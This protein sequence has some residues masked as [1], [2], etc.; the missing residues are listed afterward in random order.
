[1][2]GSHSLKAWGY[3]LGVLKGNYG[4]RQDAW[5]RWTPEMQ[6][7]CENDTLVTKVL[8]QRCQQAIGDQNAQFASDIEHELAWY[9]AQQERNGAPFNMEAAVALQ[10]KL[11]AKREVIGKELR[12]QFGSWL[13][14]NGKPVTPKRDNKKKG[15]FVGAPYTKL[16][17]VEFNP[18]S[19]DHFSKILQERFGWEPQD[20]TDGGKPKMDD[21]ALESL[22]HIPAAAKVVEYL[23]IDKRLGQLAEGKQAWLKKA[24]NT[25]PE[26][27]LLTG[28][29]HI[30][31]SINQNG[32]IT[33]RAT[34]SNPNLGQVPKV[35]SPYGVESR[36]LFVVPPGWKLLG[37]DASGLELRCL[38]HYMA[39]WDEGAYGRTIL[40]GRNED[41]TDIHSVN[42]RA[43]GLSGKEGRNKAK[44]FISMG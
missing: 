16:K 35:G 32:A 30:H 36:S 44:T 23:L 38:A 8:Y 42:M 29:Y 18:G 11:S 41:G 27:G 14:R 3:R 39:K 22:E 26:G 24:T 43:L 19:R 5:E 34:H 40:E 12:E 4:D 6:R 20:F 31:G 9:L 25:G 13:A 37:S 28:M 17:V 2:V 10:A 7:Y 21:A 33:H 1:L 15:V